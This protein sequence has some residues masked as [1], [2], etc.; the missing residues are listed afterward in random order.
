V[1]LI[2]TYYDTVSSGLKHTVLTSFDHADV[3]HF[4][5]LPISY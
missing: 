3:F 1:L 4:R 5:K 2:I